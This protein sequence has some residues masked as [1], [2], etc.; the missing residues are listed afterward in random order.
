MAKLTPTARRRR[1]ECRR[2]HAN[3]QRQL[4]NYKVPELLMVAG[5]VSPSELGTVVLLLVD[6]LVASQNAQ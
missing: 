4:A 1:R 5:S 2:G 3:A 6:N